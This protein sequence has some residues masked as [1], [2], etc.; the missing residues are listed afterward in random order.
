MSKIT[1]TIDQNHLSPM[2]LEF[3]D[4]TEGDEWKYT[5]HEQAQL[6]AIRYELN[7]MSWFLEALYDGSEVD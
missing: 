4:L 1:G 3:L 5:E 2:W 7:D 6:R